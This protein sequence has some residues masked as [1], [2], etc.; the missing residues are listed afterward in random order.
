M[1]LFDAQHGPAEVLALEPQYQAANGG[2]HRLPDCNRMHTGEGWAE[3]FVRN[4][5]GG[6]VLNEDGE[7]LIKKIFGEFRVVDPETGEVNPSVGAE[8]RPDQLDKEHSES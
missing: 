7:P 6:H 4:A 1:P 3:V 5:S 8:I 2:W